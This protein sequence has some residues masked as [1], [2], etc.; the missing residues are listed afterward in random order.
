MRYAGS[1]TDI[2]GLLAGHHTKMC[3]RDRHGPPVEGL[4]RLVAID[5]GQIAAGDNAVLHRL[6]P[7]YMKYPIISP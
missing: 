6:I 4:R 7:P 1:I 5:P 3:I 2:P